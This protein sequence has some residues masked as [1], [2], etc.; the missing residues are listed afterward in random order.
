MCTVFTL[1]L[2]VDELITNIVMHA[3]QGST[4]WLHISRNEQITLV[5]IKDDA[6]R[7]NPLQHEDPDTE[8]N[9]EEREIGGLGI[10]LIK[11]KSETFTYTRENNCNI[12]NIKL[13]DRPNK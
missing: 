13:I 3:Q 10:F 9:I 8:A 2:T 1:Q 12:L 4:I 5:Q 6:H 11:E 7:F